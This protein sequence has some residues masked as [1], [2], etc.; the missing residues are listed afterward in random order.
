LD[1]SHASLIW[2]I[3]R[4]ILLVMTVWFRLWVGLFGLVLQ[5][6][7]W[8]LSDR[9][10]PFGFFFCWWESDEFTLV[11]DLLLCMLL[12]MNTVLSVISLLRS[13]LVAL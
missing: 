3:F 8:P 2:L 11:P 1:F 4:S 10:L 13:G 9:D 5:T 6:F 12:P 7:T